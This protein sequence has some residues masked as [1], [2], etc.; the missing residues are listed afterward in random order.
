MSS[1]DCTDV[2]N[3]HNDT[4]LHIVQLPRILGSCLPLTPCG[5]ND[6]STTSILPVS[7]SPKS[8]V[9]TFPSPQ[10]RPS[11]LFRGHTESQTK[12]PFGAS[13]ADLG[14]GCRR[15]L[16]F[17]R[18]PNRLSNVKCQIHTLQRRRIPIDSPASLKRPSTG[19]PCPSAAKCHRL[20]ELF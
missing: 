16:F 2:H 20:L 15:I 18:N 19:Q 4:L 11:F 3:H 5:I 7:Q 6:V 10:P 13:S 9:P 1:T 8:Q 12:R 17:T 14:V